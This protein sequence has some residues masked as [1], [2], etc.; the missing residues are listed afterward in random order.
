MKKK[1]I[2]VTVKLLCFTFA[3]SEKEYYGNLDERKATAKFFRPFL[4]D[5]VVSREEI[6]LIEN[7][8]IISENSDVAQPLNYF[9]SSIVTNLKIP[10]YTD[11]S[12]N[13]EN[14]TDPII[15]I[16]LK[17]RNHPSILT[18]VE[19][20]KKRSASPFSILEVCKEKVLGDI[21]NLGISKTCQDTNVP[22]RVIKENADIFAEFL[23]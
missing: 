20:S 18:I 1:K 13:S 9:F 7:N 23:R 10:E 17:Y 12:S 19:V 14:I 8:K 4:S 5:K 2:F 11:N 21:L 22:T 6:T 16:I 15:K 3:Q